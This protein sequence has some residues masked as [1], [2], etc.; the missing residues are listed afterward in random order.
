MLQIAGQ[1]LRSQRFAA[2]PVA[3]PRWAPFCGVVAWIKFR[4]TESGH[5]V[6]STDANL[7]FWDLIVKVS[8]LEF[9]PDHC[10][11]PAHHGFDP[12][13]L[14]EAGGF[15]PGHAAFSFN[16]R[17]MPVARRSILCGLR[18]L[19]CGPGWRNDDF[20]N[21]AKSCGKKIRQ[22]CWITNIIRVQSGSRIL[23]GIQKAGEAAMMSETALS[24]STSLDDSQT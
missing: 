22:G 4:T 10:L 6:E 17:D 8:R 21:L 11:P 23:P 5:P 19:N 20:D 15:L 7:C 1:P 3:V 18:A 13:A 16:L 9:G 12:A 2:S 14:A 24:I